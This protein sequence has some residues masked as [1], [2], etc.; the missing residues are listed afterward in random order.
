MFDYNLR[1]LAGFEP[2]GEIPILSEA[3][4]EGSGEFA[5]VSAA[6]NREPHESML[7]TSWQT[8][9]LADLYLNPMPSRPLLR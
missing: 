4:G 7:R 9:F 6:G 8:L 2:A 1:R 3:E 5:G